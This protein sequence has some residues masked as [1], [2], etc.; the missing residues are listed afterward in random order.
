LISAV[1]GGDF[2]ST[3]KS[4]YE[5]VV[6]Y[7]LFYFGDGRD[8]DAPALC[9]AADCDLCVERIATV[10][11]CLISIPKDCPP[12]DNRGRVYET[13]NLRTNGVWKMQDDPHVCG[14]A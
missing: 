8:D 10:R 6:S 14:G 9:S 11:F 2:A 1:A 12:G 3:P 4:L 13:T 5:T 7:R